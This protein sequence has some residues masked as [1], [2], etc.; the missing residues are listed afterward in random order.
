MVHGRK[1][2]PKFNLLVQMCAILYEYIA[3]RCLFGQ[4]P[5]AELPVSKVDAKVIS[6]CMC[7]CVSICK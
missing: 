2:Q 6:V 3:I 7:V 5:T 4:R 1:A